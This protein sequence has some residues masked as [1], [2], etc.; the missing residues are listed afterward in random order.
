[1]V[2]ILLKGHLNFV[3]PSSNHFSPSPLTSLLL[4][5]YVLLKTWLQSRLIG[6]KEGDLNCGRHR[7][8][9]LNFTGLLQARN[10]VQSAMQWQYLDLYLRRWPHLTVLNLCNQKTVIVVNTSKTELIFPS[11]LLPPP[12]FPCFTK[13]PTVE[14]LL[15]RKTW[16][17]SLICS[18]ILYIHVIKEPYQS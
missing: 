15:K 17:P 6:L 8:A 5:N 2:D 7:R 13:Q 1:M 9:W 12:G 11:D 18:L 3:H 4:P 14:W 16:E 10:L